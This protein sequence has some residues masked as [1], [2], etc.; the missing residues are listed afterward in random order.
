M[1]ASIV[2]LR[3]HAQSAGGSMTAD[4]RGAIRL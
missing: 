1:A 3:N 2:L 4:I